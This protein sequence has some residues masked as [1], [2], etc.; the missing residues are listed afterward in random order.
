MKES[1]FIVFLIYYI[2]KK[3]FV[4]HFFRDVSIE[5]NATS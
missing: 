4:R 3:T 5:K 1:A 2:K